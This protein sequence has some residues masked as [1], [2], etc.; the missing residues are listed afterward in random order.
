MNCEV[1]LAPLETSISVCR[2]RYRTAT[3]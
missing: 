2:Y 1:Y 3:L